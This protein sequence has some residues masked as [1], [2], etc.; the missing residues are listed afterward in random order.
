MIKEIKK[1]ISEN[2]ISKSRTIFPKSKKVWIKGNQLWNFWK[3]R[4]GKDTQLLR[5]RN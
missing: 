5:G 3:E 1:K 2:N 4:E